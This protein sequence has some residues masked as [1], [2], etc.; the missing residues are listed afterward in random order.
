M[1]TFKEIY[2]EVFLK[3]WEREWNY[4]GGHLK[5]PFENFQE[6]EEE[7]I[8]EECMDFIKNYLTLGGK[9]QVRLF[10]FINK[11][12]LYRLQHIISTFFLGIYLYHSLC[13]VHCTIDNEINKILKKSKIPS[14]VRIDFTYI[15][16]LICLFHDLGYQYENKKK[17]EEYSSFF[18]K[19]CQEYLLHSAEGVPEFYKNIVEKYFNYHVRRF[20]KK[21]H[22]I[23]CARVLFEDLCKIRK[24]KEESKT[25]L[26]WGKDLEAIYNYVAWI[27]L[28]HNIWYVKKGGMDA[29]CYEVTELEDLILNE[30]E[31]KITLKEYPFLFLF[32]LVDGIEPVK[33]IYPMSL[34]QVSLEINNEKI[35]LQPNFNNEIPKD[36]EDLKGWLG[37]VYK[38]IDWL[39]KTAD[40][41][42]WLTKTEIKKDTDTDTKKEKTKYSVEINLINN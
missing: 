37:N 19:E 2:G 1:K 20:G 29:Y 31:Y 25:N 17:K 38:C 6:E 24:G 8:Q 13:I 27:I 21:E 33:R 5:K 7:S 10:K 34:D 41:N 35:K 11:L 30:N 32:C 12:D 16:F 26:Y 14:H 3:S 22:G 28:A 15:W 9:E 23:C 39:S 36:E 18:K 4:Y 40:L 42:N